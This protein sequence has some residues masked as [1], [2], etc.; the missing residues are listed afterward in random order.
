MLANYKVVVFDLDGTLYEGT[1][2][3]DYYADMLQQQV[4]VEH[5]E[6]F[7]RDYQ[8]IKEGTHIVSVGK[9]YDVDRDF[10]LTIDPINFNVTQAHTWEGEALSEGKVEKLYHQPLSFNFDKTV[11]I[12]DGWW[13]PFVVAKHYGV[14]DCYPSYVATKEYMVSDK[15]S[16]T[17]LSGLAEQLKK[18]KEQ[19][20]IVL[21][22]NSEEEDVQR[23]LSHLQLEMVFEHVITSAQKP[24]NAIKHFQDIVDYYNVRTE[25]VVS[26]GDNFINEISP[27]LALGIRGIYITNNR[28]QFSHSSYSVV[29]SVM[30]CFTR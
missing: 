10:V 7:K 5:R 17:P 22:T 16:L 30:A 1:D 29:P 11:A 15:F 8:Q 28:T 9:V 20:H 21:M 4:P 26:V 2:H 12:G 24:T 3:F 19:T 23:L 6:S 25:E 27:A 13:L 14:A 18:L